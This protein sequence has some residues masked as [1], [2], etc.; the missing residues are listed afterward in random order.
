MI[1]HGAQTILKK[2]LMA[3]QDEEFEDAELVCEGQ[4]CYVG[5][6]RTTRAIVNELL[7]TCLVR[8][9]SEMDGRGVERYELN[10]DGR[11][12]ALDRSWVNP[13]LVKALAERPTADGGSEHG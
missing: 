4:E 13:D 7:M 1:S 11:K 6:W 2:M 12:A 8:A 3:E 9:T 5:Y 10:E